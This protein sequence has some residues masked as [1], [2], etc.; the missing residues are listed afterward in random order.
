MF[1]KVNVLEGSSFVHDGP[2]ITSAGGAKSFDAALYLSELLYGEKAAI[3]IGRGMCIDWDRDDID[4][5][6]ASAKR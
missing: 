5:V 6:N 1:P 2:M 4:F 3:G